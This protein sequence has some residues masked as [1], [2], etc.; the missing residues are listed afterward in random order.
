MDYKHYVVLLETAT[1]TQFCLFLLPVP[2][3]YRLVLLLA[4][5]IQ[6]EVVPLEVFITMLGQK[7]NLEINGCP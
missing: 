1:S 6:I 2:Y 7:F 4:W 5:F 3:K